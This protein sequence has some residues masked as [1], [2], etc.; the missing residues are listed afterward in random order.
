MHLIYI[1][2]TCPPEPGATKRPLMQARALNRL[3]HSVTLITGFPSYPAG[4]VQSGYRGKLWMRETLAGVNILRVW[5]VPA[6]TRGVFRRFISFFTFSLSS[7][8]AGL[9]LRRADCVIASIPKPFTEFAGFA[10]AR[11]KKSH[12]VIEVR[13]VLPD[14]LQM[15]QVKINPRLYGLLSRYYGWIYRRA[16]LFALSETMWADQLDAYGVKNT[17]RVIVPHAF[18][19]EEAHDGD[20]EN[21]RHQLKVENN[22]VVAYAGSFSQH[23]NIPVFVKVAQLLRETLPSARM[24]LIGT[25]Y[26]FAKIERLVKESNLNN[27]ILPGGVPPDQVFPY[28][29][30]ADLLLL[31]QLLDEVLSQTK[32]VEYLASATPVVCICKNPSLMRAEQLGIGISVPWGDAPAIASAIKRLAEDPSARSDCAAKGYALIVRERERMQVVA[33]LESGLKVMIGESK[34]NPAE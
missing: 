11:L 12:F 5:S 2:Q 22:F 8:I 17:P 23:Y 10:I 3:G 24:L 32:I 14:T 16:D 20:R 9:L 18:D 4:R 6:P 31:P 33:G 13:D 21:T 25:G 15:G 26:D 28:L 1:S 30:A 19:R 34:L 29:Q 27:V 7:L